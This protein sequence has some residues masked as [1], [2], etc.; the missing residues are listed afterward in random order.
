MVTRYVPEERSNFFSIL[1]MYVLSKSVRK[2]I[3]LNK[4]YFLTWISVPIQDFGQSLDFLIK[5]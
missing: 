1:M 3:K 5:S 4:I 2:D